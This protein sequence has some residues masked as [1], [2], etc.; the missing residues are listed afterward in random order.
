M[1]GYSH[2]AIDGPAGSGKTTVARALA[3]RIGALYLDTGA[4][5]RALAVT[6][7]DQGRDPA[8][9]SAMIDLARARPVRVELD[10]AAPLGF[11]IYAGDVQLGDELYANRVSSVVSIVSAHPR[12]RDL[13][14]ERQR[15]MAGLGPV[16]MAGRDIGTV[17]L[18]NAPVKVF[19]TA[20][21]PERVER[22]GA[23]LS[24]RGATIDPQRLRDEIVERDRLDETRAVAPLRA[25]PDAVTIDSSGLS[26]A[27]VVAQIAALVNAGAA[28]PPDPPSDIG[29]AK[30]PDPPSDIG[31]A[32]PPDPPRGAGVRPA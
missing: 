9:E 4:M 2:V 23:E 16:V 24:A 17:V 12:V 14:V 20:S 11:R 21:L 25:A 32:K 22:R 13:M 30:P 10:Q 6:A 15:E 8:D 29:A 31:A 3:R 19:L 26:V 7:L 27:E 28:K 1:S 18:P 5:Y